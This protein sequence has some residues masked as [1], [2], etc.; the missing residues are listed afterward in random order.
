MCCMPVMLWQRFLLGIYTEE[1]KDFLVLEVPCL[2]RQAKAI[3]RVVLK[4]SDSLA[5]LSFALVVSMCFCVSRGFCVLNNGWTVVSKGSSLWEIHYPQEP[6]AHSPSVAQEGLLAEPP[7]CRGACDGRL[8]GQ[9][10]SGQRLH[11]GVQGC[12]QNGT[13]RESGW[14]VTAF[15]CVWSRLCSVWKRS[16]ALSWGRSVECIE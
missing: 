6:L 12:P 9:A 15:L 3:Q 10:G 1:G 16:L 2:L 13:R 5:L 7:R 8:G 4:L 14:I 11:K